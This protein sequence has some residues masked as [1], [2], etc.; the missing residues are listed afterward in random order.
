MVTVNRNLETPT[1]PTGWD[2]YE[3]WSVRVRSTARPAQCR[4]L[5]HPVGKLARSRTVLLR[6][7]RVTGLL[8]V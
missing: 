7:L 5:R 1:P 8:C 4:A 6:T 3:V 2:P